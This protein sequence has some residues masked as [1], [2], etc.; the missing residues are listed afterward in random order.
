MAH[1][2]RFELPDLLAVH[3]LLH[4]HLGRGVSCTSTYD[5]LGKNVGELLRSRHVVLP[6]HFLN[7]GKL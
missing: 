6:K 4:D 3:F 2:D 7:R 5:F 1:Q